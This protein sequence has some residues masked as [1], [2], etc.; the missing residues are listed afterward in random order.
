MGFPGGISDKESTWQC[1]RHKRFRSTPGSGRPY[2]GRQ[3]NPLQYCCLENP[4][5]RGAW[6]ATDYG[7]TKSQTWLNQFSARTHTHTH[8]H[9]YIYIYIFITESLCYILETNTIN[10]L[11]LNCFLK[12]GNNKKI[13]RHSPTGTHAFLRAEKQKIPV[14]SQFTQDHSWK[15]QS[16]DSNPVLIPRPTL[17]QPQPF[18][19]CGHWKVSGST[20]NANSSPVASHRPSHLIQREDPECGA[21]NLSLLEAELTLHLSVHSLG[22]SS[23]P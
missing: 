13:E 9:T 23:V 10:Q 5:D 20:S 15:W 17:F 3:G 18:L 2:G 21:Q 12:L 14:R 16:W 6:W 7:V 19:C 8:T 1:R 4:R 22:I 11:Y